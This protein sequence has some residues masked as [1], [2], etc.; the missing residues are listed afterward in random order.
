MEVDCPVTPCLALDARTGQPD[1]QALGH[2]LASRMPGMAGPFSLQRIDGGQSNPSWILRGAQRAWIVRAK[3]GPA[4]TLAPSAHAIEREYRVLQA[5]AG[6]AV[7]V[8]QVHLLCEDESVLGAAFY[9]MDFVEGRVFRDARLPTLSADERQACHGDAQGVLAALHSVDWQAAGLQ[10]YGKADR[11]FE[12]LTRR[13]TQ[14]YQASAALT[15]PIES[16]DRLA[17]WL[18]QHVPAGADDPARARLTHGDFRI[19]NLM[20]HPQR[21]QVVAVL[22]WELSTVG[23]PLSDLAYHCIAWHMPAGPLQGF[24]GDAPRPAGVP[25]ERAY[26]ERYCQRT[27]QDA[28][29]VLADWPFYLGFNLFRLGAILAGIGARLA[30]GTAASGQAAAVA[31]MAQPVA[32]LGWAI[33]QG[34]APALTS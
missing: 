19:E 8:P 17:Q 1:A 18:A 23:Q 32:D 6:S 26:I 34:H 15:R 33:T 28:Q 10:D 21:P 24:G 4:A 3:P 31:A 9:V 16:M 29:R 22:D 14:Q 2:W 11:F 5:L 12:R 25:G 30:Q 13:W 20:F 7:P 27:G